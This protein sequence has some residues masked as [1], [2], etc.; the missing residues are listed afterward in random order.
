MRA[1]K[2][3]LVA[4]DVHKSEVKAVGNVFADG[5]KGDVVLHIAS[6]GT[7]TSYTF[8]DNLKKNGTLRTHTECRGSLNH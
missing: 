7:P 3:R 1:V 8:C 6:W 2:G 4:N 5:G